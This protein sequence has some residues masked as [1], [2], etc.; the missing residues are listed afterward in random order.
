MAKLSGFSPII[1]TASP[2]NEAHLKALGATHVLDRS[3]PLPTALAELARLTEGAPIAYAYDAVSHPDTQELAYRALAP[4]G[5]LLLVTPDRVPKE[6]KAE[7]D[8]KKVVTVWGSVH[9]PQNR[10]VGVEMYKRLTEWLETGVVVVRSKFSFLLTKV[11]SF[12]M[13]SPTT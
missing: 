5:R 4:G 2:R 1:T 9:L 6:L 12:A 8:G 7:G 13:R 10:K 3:L 11:C